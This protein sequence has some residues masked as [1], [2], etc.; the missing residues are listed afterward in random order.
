[1]KIAQTSKRFSAAILAALLLLASA[2][3]G[4]AS[5]WT[6]PS[7]GDWFIAG[8]WDTGVPNSS[9]S[10]LINNGGTALLNAPGAAASDLLLGFVPDAATGGGNGTL[11]LSGTPGGSRQNSSPSAA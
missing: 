1:M 4:F 10:A 9:T 5:T 6:N 2:Q 3:A 7:L 8:N 11:L